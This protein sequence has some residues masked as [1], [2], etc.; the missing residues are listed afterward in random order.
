[1]FLLFNN[2]KILI[3]Q[4]SIKILDILIN[5]VKIGSVRALLLKQSVNS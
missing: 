2:G 4:R 5:E 1:M 3:N